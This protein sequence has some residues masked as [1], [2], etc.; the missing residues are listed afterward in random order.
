MSALL[1][2]LLLLAC[3]QG[4]PGGGDSGPTGTLSGVELAL[5]EVIPTVVTVRWPA[6]EGSTS[7]SVAFGPDGDLRWTAPAT[8][9]DGE[10]RASLVGVKALT[11][12]TLVAEEVLADGLLQSEE[13]SIE[14]GSVTND[15]RP[16]ELAIDEEG[17]WDQGFLLGTFVTNPAAAVIIDGDGDVVWWFEYEGA[18]MVG[19]ARASR[20]GQGV[21]LMPINVQQETD[22]RIMK[23][24]WDGTQTEYIE[25]GSGHHDFL[26]LEDG[27]FA[28]LT[29][30]TQEVDGSPVVGDA[31]ILRAADGTTRTLW[32][33]WDWRTYDPSEGLPGGGPGGGG[34]GGGA[35][36]VEWTHCNSLR[37]QDGAFLVGS[38]GLSAIMKVDASS[39]ELLWTFGSSTSDFTDGDGNPA[40]LDS[41]H[42]FELLDGS[43]LVFENGP[44]EQAASRAVE[45][46][47]DEVEPVVEELWS[48]WPDPSIY[49]F[50]LGNPQRLDNGNTLVNFATGGQIDEVTPEGRVVWRVSSGLGGAFGYVEQIDALY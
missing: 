18:E 17:H 49:A 32:S 16:M 11:Q 24:S 19:R 2:S 47:F 22:N 28:W 9:V 5:S 27:G 15:I 6:T 3:T 31:L 39:G 42:Q 46:R 26:E 12:A 43:L 41:Q 13:L 10:W 4:K 38:L 8:R 25:V 34:P 40:L 23:V 36:G 37:Y 29:H 50:S 44:S 20:D 33:I 48:Y 21:F 14:T 7:A 45:F 1:P 30:D 35:G